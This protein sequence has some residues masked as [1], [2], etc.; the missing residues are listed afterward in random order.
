MRNHLFNACAVEQDHFNIIL[1]ECLSNLLVAPCFGD[2]TSWRS[3][4][5]M[6]CSSG[7]KEFFLCNY[8]LGFKPI[9]SW[10]V[11]CKCVVLFPL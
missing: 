1:D 7:S 3:V 8:L 4:S 10:L 6:S 5:V 11:N 9:I 2:S